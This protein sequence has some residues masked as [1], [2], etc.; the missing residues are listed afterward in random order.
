MASLKTRLQ[1]VQTTLPKV[2]YAATIALFL[3]LVAGFYLPGKGFSAL[4]IF[5]DKMQERALPEL[6]VLE[7]Y[8]DADS[9][10]YDGQFY[11]QIAIRP[12]LRSEDLNTAVDNL[13]YRA[14]RILLS[15]TAWALGGGEPARVLQVYALQNV[16]CWLALAALLLRWFP[17][18]NWENY[19][20]WAGTLFSFGMCFSVRGSLLDGPSLLLIAIGVALLERGR[21]WSATIVLGLSGL[22]RETNI[23]AAPALVEPEKKPVSEWFW[24]LMRAALVAVPLVLWLSYLYWVFGAHE[25]GGTGNLNAPFTGFGQKWADTWTAVSTNGLTEA[26]FSSLVTMI[27]L[28]VQAS[29][30]VCAPRWKEA[31]WRI[32]IM[33]VMLMAILGYAVWEGSPGASGRA[34]LPMSLAF[35]V[36]LPRGRRWWLVLLL[37]NIT[38]FSAFGAFKLPGMQSY[39]VTGQEALV[40]SEAREWTVVFDENWYAAER[41]RGEYWRWSSGDAAITIL[42]PHEQAVIAEVSFGL[43]SK[44]ERNIRV[45]VAGKD[46]PLW[47]GRVSD[48]VT[49][50]SLRGLCI[51]PGE[52]VWR[53]ETDVPGQPPGPHDQRPVAFSLRN[54]EFDLRAKAD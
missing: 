24:M 44:I 22:M 38:V 47:T 40:A 25:M 12:E 34:L 10:G 16:V 35:N 32:G 21:S 15:W 43:R 27:A 49:R 9:Y 52:T 5:G 42:N 6:K 18:T 29:Y 28:T 14:R 36:L 19:V 20:R 50:V 7:P 39:R 37:G 13:P 33:Y 45:F 54:L 8:M 41:S 26:V 1:T 23:L 4:I 46:E 17:P 30:L 2:A 3:W 51:D 48:S 11:A 53:F 31:W